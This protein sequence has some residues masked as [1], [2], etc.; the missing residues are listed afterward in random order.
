[1]ADLDTVGSVGSGILGGAALGATIGTATGIPILGT[2]GGAIIGGAAGGLAAHKK[3]EGLDRLEEIPGFDPNQLDFLDTLKRE[4][5]SIESGFTTD[6][7]VAKDLNQQALAGGL[8]VAGAVAR[9]NPSLGLSY[10]NNAMTKYSTGIN[11]ALGTISTRSLAQSSA[12]GSLIGDISQRELD[13]ETYKTAQQLGMAVSDLKMFNENM[14]G[15][16]AQIPGMVDGGMFGSKGL[17][18]GIV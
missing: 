17:G 10:I 9:S 18:K 4:K 7:Q 12:V 6:F 15:Q 2:I 3:G 1:M 8:S 11:K 16:A 14:M 13:V 5:R